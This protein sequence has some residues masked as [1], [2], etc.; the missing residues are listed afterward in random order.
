MRHALAL[1]SLSAAALALA[2]CESEK[3]SDSQLPQAQP[4]SWEQQLP[5]MS[6]MGTGVR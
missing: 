1:L 6:G 5:G 4:A 3:P 2:G